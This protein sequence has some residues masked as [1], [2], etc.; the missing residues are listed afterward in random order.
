MSIL[1]PLH[2]KEIEQFAQSNT[3]SVW[4]DHGSSGLLCLTLKS[5]P[6]MSVLHC[7]SEITFH[8]SEKYN[9]FY[10]YSIVTKFKI[11]SLIF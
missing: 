10:T 3:D 5:I 4:Q 2:L 8:Q 11:I 7:S 9:F 1:I 6:L